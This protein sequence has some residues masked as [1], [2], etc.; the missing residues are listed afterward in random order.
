MT[1]SM[2]SKDLAMLFARYIPFEVFVKFIGKNISYS[3]FSGIAEMKKH[4]KEVLKSF[5]YV[6]VNVFDRDTHKIRFVKE[7][8]N[9]V[10]DTF[11]TL[12]D[13]YQDEVYDS[14]YNYCVVFGVPETKVV[15]LEE[16]R[17]HQKYHAKLEW[18]KLEVI[19][20][21]NNVKKVHAIVRDTPVKE[22]LI[23][24]SVET[25]EAVA[26][27]HKTKALERILDQEG[28]RREPCVDL[29]SKALTSIGII[30]R[31]TNKNAVK[32]CNVS[33]NKLEDI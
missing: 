11:C 32:I 10:A 18:Y 23:I 2:N 31:L 16:I 6:M 7:V 15:T 19:L 13:F 17:Y 28:T 25:E 20:K 33:E 14:E 21:K 30:G 29:S 24:D 12:T 4:V 26:C 22:A 3:G 5:R 1:H 8:N 9:M 27:V